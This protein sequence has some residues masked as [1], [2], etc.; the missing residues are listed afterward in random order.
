MV[1]RPGKG[2]RPELIFYLEGPPSSPQR[3]AD[4]VRVMRALLYESDAKVRYYA[5]QQLGQLYGAA[6]P[7]LHELRT[8]TA[9]GS[10]VMDG[11][12]VGDAAADAI[13]RIEADFGGW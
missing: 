1:E 5:A 9:D 10:V 7:A 2:S 3:A 11:V 6:W 12:T 13:L 4:S 8:A